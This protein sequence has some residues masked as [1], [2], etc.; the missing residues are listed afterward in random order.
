MLAQRLRHRVTVQHQVPEYT[1]GGE[2]VGY[3]WDEFLEDVP[4]EVL[5]GPGREFN[6]A[7]A[8]QAETTA[9]MTLRWFPGLLP[10]MR[11]LWDGRVF[12]IIGEP[13]TDITGRMEWRLRC[14]G[15]V[16]DGA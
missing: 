10:D 11:I 16:N 2:E 6:A 1:S 3:V 15:G 13:E 8:K 5:T 9:R 12:D 14:K 4:A 7:D